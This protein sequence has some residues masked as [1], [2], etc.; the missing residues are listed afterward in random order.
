MHMVAIQGKTMQLM[1]SD[2]TLARLLAMLFLF[3]IVLGS[4][5]I[6]GYQIV[7]NQPINPYVLALVSAGI[8]TSLTMFGIHLGKTALTP[9]S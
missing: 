6:A 1:V 4:A 5:A 7:Q 3:F 2:E 8:S 9:S